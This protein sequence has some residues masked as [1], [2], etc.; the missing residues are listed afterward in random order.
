MVTV[1]N[2]QYLQNLKL[3]LIYCQSFP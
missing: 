3:L 2:R 1:F